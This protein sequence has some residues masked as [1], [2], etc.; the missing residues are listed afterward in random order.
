MV[1][2]LKLTGDVC[3]TATCDADD[4]VVSLVRHEQVAFELVH[5]LVE[6]SHVAVRVWLLEGSA[7]LADLTVQ[8]IHL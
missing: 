5:V 7:D 6:L 2:V 1:R 3:T 8:V 4:Q